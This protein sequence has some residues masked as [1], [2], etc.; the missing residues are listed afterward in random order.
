MCTK[1]SQCGRDGVT[2]LPFGPNLPFEFKSKLKAPHIGEDLYK[3][4]KFKKQVGIRLGRK[5]FH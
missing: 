3:N 4:S 2:I 1:V 5:S